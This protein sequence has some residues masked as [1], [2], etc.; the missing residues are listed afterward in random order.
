MGIALNSIY[1]MDFL[2]GV[3]LIEDD[4]VDLIVTDPPYKTTSRG[5]TG[6]SG[7]MCKKKEFSSGKVFKYNDIKFSDYLPELH[8]V[9]KSG[10]HC[11]I[12]CNHKNL[13][14]LLN[15]SQKAGFHFIKSLIW[16]KGNK[17]MGQCY[18]SQFEYIIFQHFLNHFPKVK[19]PILR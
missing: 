2:E 7:G 4:S 18:M 11:Y 9:L 17:I 6:N 8:R 19:F 10:C 12:M 14:E 5:G 1:N 3:S 15:E 13:I 16:N